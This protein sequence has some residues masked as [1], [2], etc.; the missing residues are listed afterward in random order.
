MENLRNL[1][2]NE[3]TIGA[4]NFERGHSVK[5]HPVYYIRMCN[6][7]HSVLPV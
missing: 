3:Q 7:S 4:L 2:L 6:G 5:N 1:N